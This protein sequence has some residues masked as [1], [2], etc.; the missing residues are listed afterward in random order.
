MSLLQV[1]SCRFRSCG[2][3]WCHQGA[4]VSN[5]R[6]ETVV[7]AAETTASFHLQGA[8]QPVTS[9]KTGKNNSNME[10]MYRQQG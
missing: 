2:S 5:G 9:H 4:L 10:K 8:T 1:L 7:S 3:A 6:G